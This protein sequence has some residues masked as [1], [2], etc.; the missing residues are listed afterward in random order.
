VTVSTTEETTY[1]ANETLYLNLSAATNGATI[2]DSQGV[3]TIT[4]DDNGPPNAVND[5]A[6]VY[7]D[8]DITIN[9]LAN[10]TDPDGDTLSVISENSPN[11]YIVG[12]TK[13]N[14][15]Y[16]VSGVRTIT[17]TISDGNGGTDSA[18]ITLTVMAGQ[19]GG[20]FD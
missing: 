3:G 14:C 16:G 4:N 7:Q 11:C 19:G 6:S 20:P 17:Y 8:K 5:S 15:Q 1:E 12:T 9:V 13:V 10:D 18:T 2:S